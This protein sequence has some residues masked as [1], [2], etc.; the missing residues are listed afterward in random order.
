[1]NV[2]VEVAR[3]M[4]VDE[5]EMARVEMMLMCIVESRRHKLEVDVEVKVRCKK[6]RDYLQTDFSQSFSY[7]VF[8]TSSREH[9]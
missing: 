3:F 6:N 8:R 9:E 7:V 4:W 5:R 1:M 2:D